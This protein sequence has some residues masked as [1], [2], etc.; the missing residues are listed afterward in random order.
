MQQEIPHGTAV[1][2]E[3]MRER[4]DR[5]ILDIEA[6][7]YCEKASHKG[8]IIGKGGQ[9][10]KRIASAARADL[11][12]FLDTKVNLQCWV[13]VREDWRNQESMIRNFGLSDDS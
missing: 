6:T 13:K 2:I 8:M 11:E 4:E 5:P 7:I 10:L 3:K 1:I 12:S 9:P